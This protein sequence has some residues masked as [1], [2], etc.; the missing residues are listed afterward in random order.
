MPD[1]APGPDRSGLD[2][3]AYSQEGY[4]SA[5]QAAELGFSA[6]LLA[7]HTRS[8]RFERV[9]RGL[10]RLRDY[11]V[12]PH[13]EIHAA[14][15][16]MRDRAV[17]S[18]ESALELHGLSDVMPDRVHL[19][20]SR[21]D[22]GARVPPGVA[23]HT[24]ATLPAGVDVSRRN[25]IVLTSPARSIVD[26]AAGGTAPEQI[27]AAIRHALRQGMTTAGQ[28]RRLAAARDR[29]VKELVERSLEPEARRT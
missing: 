8:G 5:G 12:S 28:L 7:H 14:W 18:H 6:Q 27:E 26:A 17:V 16:P 25:G 10:Y 29:R 21:A 15:L 4:F 24:T 19:T 13:E 20:V 23:L 1:R 3:L 11:P 2:R 22:R 9:R